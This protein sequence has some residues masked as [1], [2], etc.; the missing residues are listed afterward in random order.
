MTVL[1]QPPLTHFM[2]FIHEPSICWCCEISC[3]L[4]RRFGQDKFFHLEK[5]SL[6]E[7]CCGFWVEGASWRRSGFLNFLLSWCCLL[8]AIATWVVTLMFTWTSNSHEVD[9]VFAELPLSPL[10]ITTSE[11]TQTVIIF[12]DFTAQNEQRSMW[13]NMLKRSLSL[14]LS[15]KYIYI[16][17]WSVPSFLRNL[18]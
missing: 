17:I 16:Y 6:A 11:H 4:S 13:I 18:D 8:L 10:T 12:R 7:L 9:L 14:S 1:V 15:D 5:L 3:F 2:H